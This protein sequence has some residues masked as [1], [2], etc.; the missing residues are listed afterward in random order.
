MSSYSPQYDR[1]ANPI[2]VSGSNSIRNDIDEAEVDTSE[3]SED[4]LDDYINQTYGY[5]DKDLSNIHPD[6]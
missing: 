4:E 5:I 6:Y 3:M 2:N 1:N